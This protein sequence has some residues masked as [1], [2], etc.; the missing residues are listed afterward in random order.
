[1]AQLFDPITINSLRLE[2]RIIMPCLDPGFAEEGGIVTPR[3][4]HYFLRRARGGVAFIMVGPAVID[5]LGAGGKFEYRLYRD[6]VLEGLGNLAEALH[7]SGVSVGLQLHHAGRQANPAL[8]SGTPVAPS[9]IMCPVRRTIPREL[10]IPWIEEIVVRYGDAAQRAKRA[11]FD[12]VEIHGSHGYLIAEFL[13]PFSNGR[14]DHYGGSIENRTRFATEVVREV[15]ARVGKDYPIFFRIPG[16]EHVPGGLG[17]TETP[18]IAGLMENAG[19]DAIDVSAGTYRSAEWIVPPMTLPRGCNVDAAA[20]IKQEVGIPVIVAGRIN[21]PGLAERILQ[22]GHADAVAI[23]RGLVA[24]PDLPL[25]TKEGK[26]DEIRPCIA[27]NACIDR[28]FQDLDIV[29]TVNPEVG[30][31]QEFDPAPANSRKKVMV[32]GGGPAGMEASRVAGLRGHEVTLFEAEDRVGG[33]LRAAC[34]A[35]FKEELS[36]LIAYY[37]TILK[38]LGT[39]LV[40]GKRVSGELVSELKPDV[41]VVALG[42]LPLSLPIPGAGLPHVVQALDVLMDRAEVRGSAVVIGGGTVGC[43]TALF[44]AERGIKVTVLEAGP[45]VAGGIPRL[46]GKMIKAHMGERGIR[47]ETRRPVTEIRRTGVIY[48]EEDGREVVVPGDWVV[49][50]VGWRS[51]DGLV[52]DLKQCGAPVHIIGDCLNPRRAIDAFFEGA[53]VGLEI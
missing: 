23:A 16:S 37:E 42:A 20:K 51:K 46:L 34:R 11:G 28:L 25:K 27:C 36:G 35:P 49:L 24:D 43:E 39:K 22:E 8:I 18:L 38:R 15:R 45:Y 1:M 13:S 40:L 19:V 21:N 5:P 48:E 53:K 4:R 52:H 31:E 47:V 17:E 33:L 41:L 44:L 9:P 26:S 14:T 6:E 32:I 10:T 30:R 7:R 50:A 3:L 2:N 29:C 12:A